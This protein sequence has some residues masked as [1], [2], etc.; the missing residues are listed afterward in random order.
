M[1]SS[2]TV[3]FNVKPYVRNYGYGP[4]HAFLWKNGVMRDLGTLGGQYSVAT[5]LNDSGTIGGYSYTAPNFSRGPHAFVVRGR[6]MSDLGALPGCSQSL[7]YSIN[8]QWDDSRR[9]YQGQ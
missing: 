6:R 3:R 9:L 5:C 2:A 7:A 1:G 4:W 8:K